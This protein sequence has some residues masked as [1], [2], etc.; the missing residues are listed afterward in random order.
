MD[1]L[2]SLRKEQDTKIREI[3]SIDLTKFSEV[4]FYNLLKALEAE[5][6]LLK[7]TEEEKHFR[8]I[9]A[10][11]TMIGDSLRHRELFLRNGGFNKYEI[12]S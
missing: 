6:T 10:I 5:L 9:E 4:H 8:N 7:H 12:R 11:V 2:L 1:E 3:R